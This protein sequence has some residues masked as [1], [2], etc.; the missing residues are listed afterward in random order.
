MQTMHRF[1]QLAAWVIVWGTLT[2]TT[3]RDLRA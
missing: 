1:E 2:S 3:R